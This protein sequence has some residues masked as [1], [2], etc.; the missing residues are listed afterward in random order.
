MITALLVDDE[1][2]NL[3]MLR[4]LLKENCPQ[5]IILDV[6]G[7][8]DEAYVK[9]KALKP[10][11]L[12]L[13]IMMP[14][15]SGFDLLR[16]FD[17][18]EF[19][20]IFV[21]AFNEFALHAFDFNAIDY[22]LKPIDY[23]KLVRAVEKASQKILK[24]AVT[25]DLVLFIKTIDENDDTVKKLSLH[26]NDKVHLIN[27]QEIAY[28]ESK[29]EYTLLAMSNNER[30]TSSKRLLLFENL[31]KQFDNFIRINKSVIIN[32]NCLR[33]Y[34]KGETCILELTTGNCFEVSRRKKNEINLILKAF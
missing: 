11:L 18:I 24:R 26:K 15:K 13:D 9:I 12:F 1:L 32:T 31:L 4:S 17:K 27:I 21:S 6:A 20:V 7:T 30:Y 2:H 14:S 34:T 19:E 23:T 28:I 22:I 16:L 33:S 10:Q 29:S 5:I 25:D 3:V 8:V